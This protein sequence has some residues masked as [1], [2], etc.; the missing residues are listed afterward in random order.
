MRVSFHFRLLNSSHLQVLMDK[1]R[2]Q[3][4]KC[5]VWIKH[6]T[7]FHRHVKFCGTAEYRVSCPYC[8]V[9]F[10]RRDDLKRHLKKKHP[11]LAE[12][13]GY[14]CGNCQKP[15]QYEMALH[16]HEE[17][18]GKE[19]PKP[20][21]C[22]FADCGKCFSRKSILEHH[23]QHYHLSQLGD[24]VKRISEEDSDKEDKKTTFPGKVDGVPEADK[25][26]S[27]MK[28]AK[29]DTFFYPKTTAQQQDQQVFFK[30]TLPRLEAHLKKTLEEKKAVKWNS[31]YTV[32]CQCQPNTKVNQWYIHSISAHL[33]QSLVPIL[34]S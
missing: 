11:E 12:S 34:S 10:A 17:H 32:K 21:K 19:K 24:G 26:V 4:P 33:I 3:C 9:T 18:R 5:G 6:S 14:C 1:V 16:L 27:A 31:V 22:T 25:E 8:P 30:D 7:H 2:K 23:Q 20:F 15:F 13:Q 28:G 29:V